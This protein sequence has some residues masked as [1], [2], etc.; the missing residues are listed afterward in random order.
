MKMNHKHLT[1]YSIPPDEECP[2]FDEGELWRYDTSRNSWVFL[3]ERTIGPGLSPNSISLARNSPLVREA[4][5]AGTWAGSRVQLSAGTWR[6][7]GVQPPA[8]DWRLPSGVQTPADDWRLPWLT[9]LQSNVFEQ[10]EKRSEEERSLGNRCVSISDQPSTSVL[11]IFELKP[12]NSLSCC[13]GK[14]IQHDQHA[15][16]NWTFSVAHNNICAS[17][18]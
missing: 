7:S 14:N 3:V 1:R 6:G 2:A 18:V 11:I 4:I 9:V 8:D 13:I 5:S 12:E 10:S 17:H 15:S 16:R